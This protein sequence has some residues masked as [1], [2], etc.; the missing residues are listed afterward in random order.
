MRRHILLFVAYVLFLYRLFTYR[1]GG[2]T[3]ISYLHL[4][5]YCTVSSSYRTLLPVSHL[6]YRTP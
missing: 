6:R 4:Y 5:L 2:M 3:R 1:G